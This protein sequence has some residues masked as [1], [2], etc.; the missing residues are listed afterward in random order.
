[1]EVVKVE[2]WFPIILNSFD[3]AESS[4]I[5]FACTFGFSIAFR[6]IG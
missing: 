4:F 3:F 5:A 2:T 6:M 1:M